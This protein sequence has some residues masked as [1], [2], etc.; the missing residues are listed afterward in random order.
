MQVK[1]NTQGMIGKW[2]WHFCILR[3][4]LSYAIIRSKYRLWEK[5][6]KIL[7]VGILRGLR[8]GLL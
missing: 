4:A 5:I 6:P 2:L 1:S 3:D 7:R 8:F